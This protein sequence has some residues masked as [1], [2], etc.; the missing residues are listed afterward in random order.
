[1]FGH[2]RPGIALYGQ[3]EKNRANQW[4]NRAILDQKVKQAKQSHM[5]PYPAIPGK[6][7]QYQAKY[8]QIG[9]SG[10]KWGKTGPYGAKQDHYG[11]KHGNTGPN[12]TKWVQT[13]SNRVQ[14][15]PNGA[16][17][18]LLGE[19]KA[20]LSKQGQIGK[21]TQNGQILLNKKW[22]FMFRNTFFGRQPSVETRPSV[23]DV[24][25]W[26][27]TFG[28]RLPSVK[29]DFRWKMTYGKRWLSVKDDFWWKMTFSERWLS[30]KDDLCWKM[31]IGGHH[32]YH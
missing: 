12:R 22:I 28:G 20:T 31:A 18:G 32:F 19:Y 11:A 2:V 27:M 9:S 4:P 16:K 24:L 29:D 3:T 8:G 17:Q 26:K 23:E 15:G 14:M 13:G 7:G 6:T 25:Q 1:M 10:A 5:V 21:M 30:V